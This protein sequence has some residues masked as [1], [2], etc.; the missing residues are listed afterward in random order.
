MHNNVGNFRSVLSISVCPI[1]IT[2]TINSN[3]DWKKL[4]MISD[5]KQADRWTD[6]WNE[7][8]LS[9]RDLTEEEKQGRILGKFSRGRVG[10]GR[11]AQKW[12]LWQTD[13]WTDRPTDPKVTNRLCP[14]LT[15]RKDQDATCTKITCDNYCYNWR[16][17]KKH[18]SRINT[19]RKKRKENVSTE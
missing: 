1:S 14:R 10:G 12:I 17:D 15:K 18:E 16:A 6:V 19:E 11:K 2:V 9:Q 7:I 8:T 13:G 5:T 4:S 3:T